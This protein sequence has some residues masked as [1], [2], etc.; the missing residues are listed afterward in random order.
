L[1]DLYEELRRTSIDPSRYVGTFVDV[2]FELLETDAFVAGVA[3]SLLEGRI[4]ES[5]RLAILR[6][7]F[8]VGTTW[9][10]RD[11]SVVDIQEA[12][13]LLAH[14]RLIESLK[15]EIFTRSNR[16]LE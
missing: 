7:P 11:G 13:A 4:I 10:L 1:N 16:I 2:V 9:E 15:K 6:R 14:A 8:L 3:S 12:P 5:E